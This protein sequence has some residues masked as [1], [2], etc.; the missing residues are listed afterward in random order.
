MIDL[1]FGI[2]F[3]TPVITPALVYG[4][5]EYRDYLERG[6]RDIYDAITNIGSI[7]FVAA[8]R[9]FLPGGMTRT[10]CVT[11]IDALLVNHDKSTG[12]ILRMGG[13]ESHKMPVIE[14]THQVMRIGI[15]TLPGGEPTVYRA[16]NHKRARIVSR[17]GD[18]EQSLDG[19][20]RIV[21]PDGKIINFFVDVSKSENGQKPSHGLIP[22]G[23]ECLAR[24]DAEQM[25]VNIVGSSVAHYISAH[26]NDHIPQ[27]VGGDW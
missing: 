27:T 7:S 1:R 20:K 11:Y 2:C 10:V 22:E 16:E 18:F 19:E 13:I 25:N 6:G 24:S 21:I 26:N 12:K 17:D 23:L 14:L 5:P 15:D 4:E 3:R 8:V 9:A